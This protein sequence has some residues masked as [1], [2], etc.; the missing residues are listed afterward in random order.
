MRKVI[1]ICFLSKAYHIRTRCLPVWRSS[2]KSRIPSIRTAP[3]SSSRHKSPHFINPLLK[4]TLTHRSQTKN[5]NIRQSNLTMW[6]KGK[7][8]SLLEAGTQAHKSTRRRS[9][10]GIPTT[11]TTSSFLKAIVPIISH[12]YTS[13]HPTLATSHHKQ[14]SMGIYIRI[15]PLIL[16]LWAITLSIS[17]TLNAQ[18]RWC[19][20]ISSSLHITHSKAEHSHLNLCRVKGKRAAQ[21]RSNSKPRHRE[22]NQKYSK[23][24]LGISLP[25]KS[26]PPSRRWTRT[27]PL[28]HSSQT[29]TY[30]KEKRPTTLSP[31]WT[32]WH[33]SS[34]T[35][36]SD[37]PQKR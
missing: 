13:P 16:P 1:S 23:D 36:W 24:L 25:S 34:T 18:T 32:Y 4:S 26:L 31:S 22:S 9:L 6:R 20:T 21:L 10:S 12:S 14:H 2:L 3:L 29:L 7:Q 8:L 15:Q 19:T 11:S 37:A 17:I 33:Q 30:N 5:S 28:S 35:E 27:S